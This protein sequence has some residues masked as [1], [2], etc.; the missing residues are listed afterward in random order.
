MMK[1]GNSKPKSLFV[2]YVL[3]AFSGCIGGHHFYLDRDI[4]AFVWWTT[5]GGLFGLG[6]LRDAWKIPQYVRQANEQHTNDSSVCQLCDQKGRNDPFSTKTTFIRFMGAVGV[7]WL[8]GLQVHHW[9]ISYTV[10]WILILLLEPFGI[11]L[12]VYIVPC[13]YSSQK[14]KSKTFLAALLCS[15]LAKWAL[16]PVYGVGTTDTFIVSFIATSGFQLVTRYNL[17]QKC[18]E[19]TKIMQPN[20]IEKKNKSQLEIMTRRALL[21][22]IAIL[23]FQGSSTVRIPLFRNPHLHHHH[24]RKSSKR[25]YWLASNPF[26]SLNSQR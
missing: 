6:W 17:F 18:Q 10:S 14:I 11:A 24:H 8:Y 5:Y 21:L 15:Y 16:I 13:T 23:L 4:Q 9:I 19:S 22:F 2:A 26:L 20:T 25:H 7:G 1:K 12:G 3:W